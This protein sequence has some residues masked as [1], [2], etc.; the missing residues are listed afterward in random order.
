MSYRNVTHLLATV[1]GGDGRVQRFRVRTHD[2]SSSGLGFLHGTFI[3]P[4]ANVQLV[5]NH[6]VHGPTYHDAVVRR[7]DHCQRHVH[8]I[9][10]EFDKPI[11]PEMYLLADSSNPT[12][13]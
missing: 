7:C 11:E 6:C 8:R 2:L 5:L 13:D 3:Y 4:G 10:V 1:K 12:S 9:G